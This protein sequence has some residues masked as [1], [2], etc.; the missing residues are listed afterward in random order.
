MIVSLAEAR[1]ALAED[2]ITEADLGLLNMLHEEAEQTVGRVLKYD[3]RQKRLTEFY[4]RSDVDVATSQFGVWDSDGQRAFFKP[5]GGQ[6][7]LQL[8]RLPVRTIHSLYEDTSGYF[9][10][11]TGAFAA[12]TELTEGDDFVAEYHLD[13]YAPS[14]LL[15]RINGSWSTTPGSIK[16][17]VTC[18][19]SDEE[20]NGTAGTGIDARPIKAAALMT[21]VKGY[22]Q[23]KINQK[24][25]LGYAAGAKS[26][27]KMGDYSYTLEKTATQ[28][29]NFQLTVPQEGVRLLQDFIHYGQMVM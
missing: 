6:Q 3:P 4:P 18:G 8:G 14:G 19:Y 29:F 20:F 10:K 13:G 24:S 26:I 23:Y 7:E 1:A 9:G 17:D 22:K 12:A 28:N 5:T 16:I 25:Q 15:H 21:L 2:T 11:K 27:E